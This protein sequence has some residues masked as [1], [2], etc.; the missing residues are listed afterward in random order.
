MVTLGNIELQGSYSD[1]VDAPLDG[2][3]VAFGAPLDSMDGAAPDDTPFDGEDD[4]TGKPRDECCLG[5]A[6]L[7]SWHSS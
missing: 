1:S 6:P 5:R 2:G 3:D 4:R 7:G